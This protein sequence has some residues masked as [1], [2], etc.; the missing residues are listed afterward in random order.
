MSMSPVPLRF[1]S[2]RRT[3]VTLRLTSL[4]LVTLDGVSRREGNKMV[5]AFFGQN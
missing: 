5:S 1:I 2:W 4:P 3:C